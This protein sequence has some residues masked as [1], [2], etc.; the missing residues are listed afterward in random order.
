[1][2]LLLAYHGF[3]LWGMILGIPVAHYFI[4]DVFG[5]PLWHERR[6]AHKLDSEP[7]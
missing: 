6:L 7:L 3:G 4:H 5:V 1:M 2:I